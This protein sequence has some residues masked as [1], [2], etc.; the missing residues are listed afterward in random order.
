MMRP[1]TATLLMVLLLNGAANARDFTL[2]A[3]TIGHPYVFETPP[4]ALTSAGYLTVT[5]DGPEADR[6]LAV[7]TAFP[8]AM[9]HVTEIDAAGVARMLPAEAMEIPAD[10]IVA[11][12]PRGAHVMFVGLDAPLMAGDEFAASLVFEKA[13]RVEVVF[14][15][16]PRTQ[17]G[18]TGHSG[19]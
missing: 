4:T 15:V 10:D 12:E 9:L 5:N 1:K 7:D 6:L 19:H 13:G 11:L 14:K 16:E 8:H 17:G 2:G 3:L 18:A